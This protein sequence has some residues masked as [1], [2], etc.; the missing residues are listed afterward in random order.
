V[1]KSQSLS[2]LKKVSIETFLVISP[3]WLTTV[4]DRGRFEHQG[5]GVPI[6]GVLDNYAY[7]VGNI[8]LGQSEDAACLEITFFGPKLEALHDTLIVICGADTSPELNGAK[9]PMWT[10]ITVRQ[11]DILAFNRSNNGCRSYLCV[12]GGIDVPEVMGSRS[13]FFRLKIGGLQGRGL[14]AGDRIFSFL[15]MNNIQNNKGISLPKEFIPVYESP[16]I[17]RVIWG[18][19]D[20]YFDK[21]DGLKTF[22]ESK[23]RVSTESNREGIRLIGPPIK[24]KS[25][26]PKSI[27]SEAFPRG[28]IQ[29]PA[30]GQ[31]II[32]LNDSIGG[33]YAKIAH[34]IT[35]DLPKVVQL[36]P[37]DSMQFKPITLPEAHEILREEEK[38][39]SRLVKIVSNGTLM[40]TID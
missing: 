35:S 39:I 27:P 25:D 21:K 30:G 7:R 32:I 4:Q 23:Y 33:G 1:R 2:I 31:P 40:H 9:I 16:A 34:V 13:T 14:V 8:L 11:G 20:D 10:V 19:Q 38:K 5:E 28:G 37:G 24:I 22:L 29:V 17:I 36:V 3:G 12:L 15:I 26:M 18:P 6:S